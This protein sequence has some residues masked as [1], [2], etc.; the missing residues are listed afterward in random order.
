[1]QVDKTIRSGD[2]KVDAYIEWMESKLDFNNTYRFIMAANNIFGA[3]ADDMEL[4]ASGKVKT[5]DK[6]LKILSD[7]KDDKFAERLN[8]VLKLADTAKKIS[9]EA[10][11]L[12]NSG[13]V[14]DPKKIELDP[15]KPAVEQLMD[16]VRKQ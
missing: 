13:K 1:M 9:A 4:I 12:I 7:D 14:A 3:M 2:A 6:K 10:E 11:A 8:M 16:R 5:S 15:T